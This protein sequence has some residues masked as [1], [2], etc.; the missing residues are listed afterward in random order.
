M[1]I[2]ITVVTLV[3]VFYAGKRYGATAEK[4]AVYAALS[5]FTEAKALLVAGV[6]KAQTEASAEV[7]RLEALAERYL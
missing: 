7:A 1:N 3:A 2:L 4:Y 6:K 5:A